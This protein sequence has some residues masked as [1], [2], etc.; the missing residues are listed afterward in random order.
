MQTTRL[1]ALPIHYMIFTESQFLSMLDTKEFNV[2]KEAA[3]HNII[4]HGM[5]NYYE[6]IQ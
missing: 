4:L 6:M 2:G 1:L 5:E 3:K